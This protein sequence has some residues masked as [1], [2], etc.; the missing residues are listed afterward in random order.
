MAIDLYTQAAQHES[1]V[2]HS[3]HNNLGLLLKNVRKDF[4]GAEAAYR[5]AIAADPGHA[6]AHSNLG[7]L[8]Q[9]E[10]KDFDGAEAAYCAAIA[11]DPG[12]AMA[13]SNLGALLWCRAQQTEKSGDLAAAAAVWEEAAKHFKVS[14]GADGEFTQKSTDNAA[15]LRIA[16]QESAGAGT[17]GDAGGGGGGAGGGR[18]KGK[19]RGGKKK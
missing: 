12:H 9:N 3:A 6:K 11:A 2:V 5:A 19:K 17:G 15:R 7:L 18:K 1:T 8:L 10:R 13:H 16:L 4:D 14:S